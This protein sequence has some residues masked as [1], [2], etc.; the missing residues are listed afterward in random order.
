M[1][2]TILISSHILHEL[3]ELCDYIGIIEQG[4]LLFS[5]RV[6]DVLAFKHHQFGLKHKW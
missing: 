4:E 5:G 1:G 6:Q 3:S 2:K